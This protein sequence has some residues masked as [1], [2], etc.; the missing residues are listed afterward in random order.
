MWMSF[1][2]LTVS[3]LTILELIYDENNMMKVREKAFNRD[4]GSSYIMFTH[5]ASEGTHRQGR[6]R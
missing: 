6:G 5:L 2:C 4:S 1:N 3:S